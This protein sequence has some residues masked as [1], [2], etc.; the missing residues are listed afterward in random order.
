MKL[1]DKFTFRYN[2]DIEDDYL[3][4]AS[5]DGN[6]V[7]V[8]WGEGVHEGSTTYPVRSV[9]KFVAED[10]WIIQEE[11]VKLPEK[12]KFVH[13]DYGCPLYTGTFSEDG[14]GF[15]VSWDDDYGTISDSNGFSANEARQFVKDGQWIIQPETFDKAE[16]FNF[17]EASM[18][19]EGTITLPNFTPV[20]EVTS[21]TE[22]VSL[23]G[24]CQEFNAVVT[25]FPDYF[26]VAADGKVYRAST[27]T[28]MLD[29][30]NT[31]R[32]LNKYKLV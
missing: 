23:Q 10:V 12:F 16:N 27:V 30:F 11:E 21:G 4:R 17:I 29:L 15:T 32:T 31:F 14:Q 20:E 3:Y 5:V 9:E 25:I 26:Q 8:S 19:T 13:K 28:G 1:P 22:Y 2:D 18:I 6:Y 24:L 7:T